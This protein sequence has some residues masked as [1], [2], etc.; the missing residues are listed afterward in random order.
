MM[1]GSDNIHA[2]MSIKRPFVGQFYFN[3]Q[4]YLDTESDF[5]LWDITARRKSISNWFIF[6]P[7]NKWF[8]SSK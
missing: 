8:I 7:I 3:E 1:T 6:W 2:M 4:K 5:I